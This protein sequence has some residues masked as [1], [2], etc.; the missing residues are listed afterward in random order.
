MARIYPIQAIFT[1]GELTPTLHSRVDLE[2][3]KMAYKYG[4]NFV[5]ARHGGLQNRPGTKF[6]GEVKDQAKTVRLV[7]FRFSRTQVYVLEFGDLYVR[8]WADDGQ[9]LDLGLPY[10]VATTYTEAELPDLQFAQSNDVIYIAHRSHAPAKLQRF[11]ET[12]WTLSDVVFIDGP[13]LPVPPEGRARLTLSGSGEVSIT[14][15]MVSSDGGTNVADIFD[16]QEFDAG[17]VT[18]KQGIITIDLGVGV[19][20]TVNNYIFVTDASAVNATES[21]RIWKVSGSQNGSTWTDL[22]SR[23]DESDWA[24]GEARYYEFYNVTAYRFYRIEFLN[25]NGGTDNRLGEMYLGQNGDFA[26]T[27]TITASSIIG[28][29]DDTGF[30]TSDIGRVIRLFATN[31]GR[32]RWFKITGRTSTTVV[33]GRLYGF[34]FR[35]GRVVTEFQMGAF[36]ETSG[37]PRTVSFFGGRLVWG[38]TISKPLGL[39]LSR[40]NAFEDFS[41]SDPLVDDDAMTLSLSSKETEEIVWITEG[42]IDLIIGTSVAIRT[43]ERSD[44]SQALSPTN[45]NVQKQ[46][47]VG[48]GPVTPVFTGSTLLYPSYHLKSLREFVYNFEINGYQAPEVSILSDHLLKPTI[49]YMDYANDPE[50]IVWIVNGAGQLIGLTYDQAN[51]VVGLHRHKI[52]GS[53]GATV[54]GVVESICVIPGDEQDDLWMVV[55]RTI[56]GNTTRYVERMTRFNDEE[57]DKA[58]AWY[59]DSA[60]LY[61]GVAASVFSGLD[62]LEGQ[63]VAVYANDQTYE[64]LVVTAGAVTL[65]S[66]TATKALIG[67]KYDP[68]LDL[69]PPVGQTPDGVNVNRKKHSVHT[70][71]D[72]YRSK[73]GKAGTSRTQEPFKYRVNGSLTE[74]PTELYTGVV[75]PHYDSRWE[76]GAELRIVQDKPYPFFIRSV[77]LT[78]DGEP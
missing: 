58:D 47:A 6:I 19:T 70:I 5:L 56:D 53:F 67:L 24:V 39:Y 23:S 27:L 21:P 18:G 31:D 12:N 13:Y 15:G 50:P 37:W 48:T 41:V 2:Y 22:D 65:P 38:G 14:S 43:L 26:T 40:V 44:G 4:E 52:G 68:Y 29:N 28:I 61:E 35:E 69:L 74:T 71:I 51:K 62:H 76:D 7:R 77:M 16:G 30:Q 63:T 42:V 3:F 20:R 78:H 46:V 33:T 59:L 73:G 1:R 57:V 36:S 66:G 60:L 45:F 49:V 64:G 17:E 9:V 32:W 25:N 34:P 11:S 54:H 8:F 75:K 55:K 10:E 72:L